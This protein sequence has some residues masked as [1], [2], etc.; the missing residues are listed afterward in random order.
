ME[1]LRA[2]S[3]ADSGDWP[4]PPEIFQHDIERTHDTVTTVRR[5]DRESE[6]GREEGETIL[7]CL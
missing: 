3:E 7:T 6:G 4:A 5:A 1:S 2:P